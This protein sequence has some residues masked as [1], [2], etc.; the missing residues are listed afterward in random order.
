MFRKNN[1]LQGHGSIRKNKIYGTVG[2]IIF[3]II[4]MFSLHKSVA[5]DDIESPKTTAPIPIAEASDT[6]LVV[7]SQMARQED[8]TTLTTTKADSATTMSSTSR[9][10]ATAPTAA[11]SQAM[12]STAQTENQNPNVTVENQELK[13][14][15]TEAKNN[16]IE[17]K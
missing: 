2:V 1:E 5:A 11:A 12:L 4:A 16:G 13:D 3:G 7:Q 17:A 10:A 15:V 14:A 9:A 6:S 8:S